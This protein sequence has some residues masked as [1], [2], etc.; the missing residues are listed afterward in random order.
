MRD[1]SFPLRALRDLQR[2]VPDDRPRLHAEREQLCVRHG[3]L[4]RG[5]DAVR[6]PVRESDDL[7]RQLRRMRPRLPHGR[8]RAS[9]LHRGGM[10]LHL[11][12]RLS[13]LRKRVR[14]GPEPEYVRRELCPVPDRRER[15][16]DVQRRRV[17]DGV[18][19]RLRELRCNRGG[20]VRS[21]PGHGLGEL[22]SMRDVVRR[23]GVHERGLR[24]SA[25]AGRRASASGGRGDDSAAARRC[26]GRRFRAP[27]AAAG[28]RG[29]D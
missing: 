1:G 23:E 11:P 20:R 28:G 18:Q 15:G 24:T 3:L 27:L 26:D 14:V 4:G 13:R 19:G 25:T 17:R 9:D 6:E 2:E 5:A 21:E 8:G 7:A 12:G 29:D 10:Q 16:L 22:R